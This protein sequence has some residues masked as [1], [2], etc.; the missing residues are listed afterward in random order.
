MHF[1]KEC[2]NIL[3]KKGKMIM[4]NNFQQIKSK[5]ES[6]KPLEILIFDKHI[7]LKLEEEWLPLPVKQ[8]Y[9]LSG[10]Y[11]NVILQKINNREELKCGTVSLLKTISTKKI[12]QVTNNDK[13]VLLY[14]SHKSLPW[15]I[16]KITGIVESQA[17][18]DERDLAYLSTLFGINTNKDA[19]TSNMK[20]SR[21]RTCANTKLSSLKK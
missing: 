20:R 16:N 21:I 10:E 4:E 1:C 3:I 9:F 15:I 13:T 8:S 6:I 11:Q 19:K 14:E 5:T 7:F 12:V 17:T 18:Y 2:S